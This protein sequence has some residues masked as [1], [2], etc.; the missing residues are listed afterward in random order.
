MKDGTGPRSVASR[1]RRNSSKIRRNTCS[2]SYIFKG[3]MPCNLTSNCNNESLAV[4]WP[5]VLRTSTPSAT[6]RSSC[7]CRWRSCPS[8]A[9]RSASATA[10]AR[11]SCSTC[12][13]MRCE[14]QYFSSCKKTNYLKM[15]I[16]HIDY[17]MCFE[18][19]KHLSVPESVPFRF[20][21]NVKDLNFKFSTLK[22][23]LDQ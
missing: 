3:F 12:A 5:P 16:V 2:S 4:I 1:R 14:W 8:S 10:T 23:N 20:T 22:S 13:P 15:Q 6:A 19:A 18:R 21:Q 11:T 17:N 9:T 7:A